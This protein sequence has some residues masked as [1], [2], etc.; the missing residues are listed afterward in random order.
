[1]S[2]SIFLKIM[3]AF[4]LVIAA[5]T[6]TMDFAI[7]PRWEQS[8]YQEIERGLLQETRLL[9]QRAA[10]HEGPL[11]SLA[12]EYSSAAGARV[13]IVDRRGQVLADS[14]ADPTRMENHAGRPEVA[15]ALEERIGI[16][17]RTSE[18]V[19]IPFLYVAA[20]YPD[21][22][23]RLAFPL[24][25]LQATT[26]QVR[27]QLLRA[28]L[29][30]LVIAVLLAL[31]A[32]RSVARRLRRITQ[33]ASQIAAGDLAARIEEYSSDE[34]GQ[35]AAALNT[36]AHKLAESF[37][38]VEA[39]HSQLETL[40]NS[41]HDAVFAVSPQMDVRWAN[42]A[43]NR[44]LDG[45]V[46]LGAPATETVR[47]PEVLSAIRASLATREPRR[48]S[49]SSVV[50]G[51]SFEVTVAPVGNAGA[52]VVL[53]DI[54]EIERVERTRRDFIANVSHELR[55][56]LTSIQGYA[57][58]LLGSAA[59]ESG[60]EFLEIIRQNAA[61]MARLTEDL[62]T[63]ASVESGEQ[64]LRLE[65]LPAAELLEDA[66][67]S[68]HDAAQARGIALRVAATCPAIVRAD[69]DAIQ[70]VFT[71][72]IDNALKYGT[73]T[74]IEIGARA[75]GHE[76]E[77][78]VRDFGAGIAS[79]HLPRLFERFYR[80]DKSRSREAGGTG[81]GLAIVKHIMRNHGGAVRA[82]SDLGRGSTFFFSLPVVKP[83]I[84]PRPA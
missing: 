76:V 44:L 28:S 78:Y 39:G 64:K 51:R 29:I 4:L 7:R 60:R 23:V 6:I 33:F 38:A 47:D 54:T 77:F 73:G 71:N 46:R 81:L 70:Q 48:T 50:R 75:A 14:Q 9:A 67:R 45:R 27:Q 37:A 20:P 58:T 36:T 3:G 18:T 19:G 15:A 61:R 11:Q 62:L 5:A 31:L 65:E 34:V 57:E 63:L 52:V 49:S 21:G 68:L 80:V 69:R 22:A 30:A 83:A 32:A 42:A 40:L 24:E 17:T 53:H 84:S 59:G 72:L 55:T 82:E 79:E 43:L 66:L 10:V 25:S 74:A 56:P 13:T 12:L 35:V 41:M 2:R 8:L 1:V 26:A 16:S